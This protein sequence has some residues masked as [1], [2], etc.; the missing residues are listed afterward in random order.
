[1]RNVIGKQG[2]LYICVTIVNIKLSRVIIHFNIKITL[3][4]TVKFSPAMNIKN[5]PD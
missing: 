4:V 2:S 5:N 3:V 1:M